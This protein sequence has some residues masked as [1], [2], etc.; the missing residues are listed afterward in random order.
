VNN[1]KAN[2][3]TTIACP[4][5]IVVLLRDQNGMP[6]AATTRS[7]E[8]STETCRMARE[9]RTNARHTGEDETV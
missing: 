6:E 2:V 8:Q 1:V 7:D 5:I 9:R 3:T 4:G